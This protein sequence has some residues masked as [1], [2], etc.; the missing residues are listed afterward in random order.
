MNIN[1]FED[2]KDL[3]QSIEETTQGEMSTH[4]GNNVNTPLDDGLGMYNRAVNDLFTYGDHQVSINEGVEYA[5]DIKP[6]YDNLNRITAVLRNQ[7]KKI[8]EKE[9]EVNRDFKPDPRIDASMGFITGKEDDDFSALKS[10]MVDAKHPPSLSTDIKIKDPTKFLNVLKQIFKDLPSD[11]LKRLISS[12]SGFIS[13]FDI[14][15][16]REFISKVESQVEQGKYYNGDVNNDTRD[17]DLQMLVGD[18]ITRVLRSFD[19]SDDDVDLETDYQSAINYTID[20]WLSKA[21]QAR[22]NSSEW[23]EADIKEKADK[24]MSGDKPMISVEE[25]RSAVMNEFES[26]GRNLN[27]LRDLYLGEKATGE[28]QPAIERPV[29][30]SIPREPIDKKDTNIPAYK[31]NEI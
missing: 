27:A 15:S 6:I 12:A 5:Y 3:S 23:I 16:V 17:K 9:T 1:G 20:E 26:G 7:L 18:I 28:D 31:R 2:L 10:A 25:V 4:L 22:A 14:E 8:N 13:T 24:P 21:V 19:G 11:Q 29:E 30:P